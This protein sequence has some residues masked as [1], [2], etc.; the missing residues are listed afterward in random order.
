M[1]FP[2]QVVNSSRVDSRGAATQRPVD[3]DGEIEYRGALAIRI[4]LPRQRRFPFLR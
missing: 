4:R 1:A 3:F 2:T